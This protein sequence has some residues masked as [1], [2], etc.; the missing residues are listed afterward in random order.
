MTARSWGV[1]VALARLGANKAGEKV[2]I[3][4]GHGEHY[5]IML[6]C[7]Y[8]LSYPR[9][10]PAAARREISVRSRTVRYASLVWKV[11]NRQSANDLT[12]RAP[13]AGNR[14]GGRDDPKFR[15]RRRVVVR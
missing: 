9:A 1:S 4:P 12:P 11:G 10:T 2:R 5:H 3:G 6:V 15:S 7:N 8:K 14:V 13:V